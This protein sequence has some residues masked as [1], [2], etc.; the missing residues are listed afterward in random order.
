MQEPRRDQ[1]HGLVG[2]A[3]VDRVAF[4]ERG[5]GKLDARLLAELVLEEPLERVAG[6]ALV[7]A[8][9]DAPRERQGHVDLEQQAVEYGVGRVL[10]AAYDLSLD[11]LETGVA[12]TAGEQV[13]EPP[14]RPRGHDAELD[15][16]FVVE[17]LARLAEIF[18]IADERADRGDD[19][20]AQRLD[21]GRRHLRHRRK[22][23]DAGDKREREEQEDHAH[24]YLGRNVAPGHQRQDGREYRQGHHDRNGDDLALLLL[25]KYPET[26]G[27]EVLEPGRDALRED[28]GEALLVGLL[29]GEMRG[30]RHDESASNGRQ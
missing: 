20:A 25:A 21:M 24:Q 6:P 8:V 13:L 30:V 1:R 19:D 10:G 28:L 22:A 2:V 27:L 23:D 29:L 14:P 26:F 5:V 3:G 16:P 11:H 18:E 9:D 17:A 7:A 4:L 12:V 15:E